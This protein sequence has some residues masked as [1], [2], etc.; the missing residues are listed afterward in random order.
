LALI[1]LLTVVLRLVFG[2][3]L[4]YEFPTAE[5][6]VLATGFSLLA[7][8]VLLRWRDELSKHERPV[9]PWNREFV[10]FFV[11]SA[12]CVGG[13]YLFSQGDV[14]VAKRYFLKDDYGAYAAAGVWAR[15]L[16]LAVSPLLTLLFTH[17]PGQHTGSAMQNQLRLLG[18]YALGLMAGAVGLLVLRRFFA[19]IILAKAAPASVT[20]ISPL[21][22]TMVSV[23]LLQALS[24]WALASRWLKLAV[25]YGGL[26][27]AYW[28][29]LWCFGKSPTELL[30]AMPLVAA[31]AFCVFFL[32]WLLAMR[33]SR[34]TQSAAPS[35]S[36]G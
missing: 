10:Q 25:L 15:A 3:V 6:A 26:G 12:A 17:R 4:T 16:P 20:M 35:S 8:F 21:A 28:L 27:L 34:S 2:A 13:S 30:R 5:V 31:A 14:L 1:G 7:N 24:L 32:T 36:I 29:T 23:G 22:F 18:I 11:V 19:Q 33:T 9:S